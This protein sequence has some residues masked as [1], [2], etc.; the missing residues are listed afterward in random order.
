MRD[1]KAVPIWVLSILIGVIGGLAT[2]GFSLSMDRVNLAAKDA[3]MEARIRI[4][5]K[6]FDENRKDVKDGLETLS[7]KIDK[8]SVEHAMILERLKMK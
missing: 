6:S 8:Y 5:E 2:F 3:D 4:L 7:Q 1:T